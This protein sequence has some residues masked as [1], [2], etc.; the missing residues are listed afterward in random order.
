[1]YDN[2]YRKIKGRF[3]NADYWSSIESSNNRAFE[4]YFSSGKWYEITKDNNYRVR[5]VQ[6]YTE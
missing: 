5:A 2:L 4:L 6:S 3:Y 1:M